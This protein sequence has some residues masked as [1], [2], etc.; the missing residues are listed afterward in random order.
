MSLTLVPCC[1]QSSTTSPQ[2]AKEKPVKEKKEHRRSLK[3][4]S[5]IRRF[6]REPR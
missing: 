3:I 1:G 2:V 4:V 6:F 5:N